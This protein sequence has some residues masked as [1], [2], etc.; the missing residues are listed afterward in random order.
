MEVREPSAQTVTGAPWSGLTSALVAA[1]EHAASASASFGRRPAESLGTA[2]A[3]SRADLPSTLLELQQQSL[4]TTQAAARIGVNPSRI[5]QK[6]LARAL[7]GFKQEASWWLPKFQFE[8]DRVVPGVEKV[9]GVIRESASPVAVARW[10][11]TPWADLVV[12]AELE[13][14]L[15]PRAWLLQGGDPALV[16]AQARLL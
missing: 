14:V 6:L 4:T 2:P 1:F 16:V 13:T 8:G 11:M 12:D 3:R 7:Y 5:R 10:F 9:F 15:S